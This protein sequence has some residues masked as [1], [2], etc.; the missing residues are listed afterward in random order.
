MSPKRKVLIMVD[1]FDTGGAESQALLLTRRLL[2]QGR[3]EPFLA[4][5]KRRGVLLAEADQ[6]GLGQ[7]PEFPLTSFYDA[8]MVRQL[9]RFIQYV[10]E[11]RIDVVHPQSFYTNI[12][13]ITGAALAR[14]PVRIA[15]RGETEGWRTPAQNF[16]ERWAYRIASAVHANS[17]AVRKYL[18]ENGVAPARIIT[19]HNGLEMS[20][21]TPAPGV[22]RLQLQAELGLPHRE[23]ESFVTIIAN[24]RHDVKDHP[25]FLRAAARVAKEIPQTRFVL[26]GE[27][28]LSG[29][30]QS[31]AAELGISEQTHFIGRCDKVAELLSLSDVCVLSSKAEG[32]SNSILEYMAAGC[33]VVATDVG[34]AREAILEGQCGFLVLSGD[35]ET[36]ADRIVL[37]LRD[38]QRAQSMGARGRQIVEERFSDRALAENTQ[39]MYDHLFESSRGKSVDMEKVNRESV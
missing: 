39:A 19:V 28:E 13:A 2:D 38:P 30:L 18:I 6:L 20:R 1:S 24:M 15:F 21:V 23:D 22:D 17:D 11:R 34:G 31:L 3:Y 26:A 25:M 32:F 7:I 16:V 5:L 27:G 35:Y 12:F 14:V 9:C 36:M 10:R 29:S 8:N 4:C 37:L 33:P